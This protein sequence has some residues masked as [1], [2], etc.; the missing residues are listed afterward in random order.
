M[1]KDN[2][3][4]VIDNGQVEFARFLMGFILI[5]GALYLPVGSLLQGGWSGII[6]SIIFTIVLVL[7][8]STFSIYLVGS[9]TGAWV[10]LDAKTLVEWSQFLW[11]PKNLISTPL[12]EFQ[13]IVLADK[14]FGTG[15]NSS[16]DRA[17]YLERNA[18]STDE[19]PAR[20]RVYLCQFSYVAQAEEK[21]AQLARSISLEIKREETKMWQGGT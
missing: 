21:A 11:K 13:S 14:K 8:A 10:D 6:W 2:N 12:D 17:I 15:T 3:I 7:P 18:S 1:H 5:A 20:A 19:D 4:V 16:T 9:R